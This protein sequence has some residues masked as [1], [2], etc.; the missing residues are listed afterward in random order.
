MRLLP[1]LVGFCAGQQFYSSNQAMR[2]LVDTE[3][4]ILKQIG[5]LLDERVS[6][7]NSLKEKWPFQKCWPVLRP[8][9][10]I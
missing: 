8:I 1:V 9:F 5:N 7:M 2:Q 3:K 4:L 6:R 10:S